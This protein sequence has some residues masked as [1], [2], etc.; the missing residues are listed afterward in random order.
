MPVDTR[1]DTHDDLLAPAGSGATAMTAPLVDRWGRI[2]R[3]LRISVTDACNIRCRYCM[4]AHPAPFLPVQRLLS[5]E[6]IE[7]LVRAVVPMGVTRLRLTGGEPLLRPH[8]ADLVARLCRVDGVEDIALTTNG[9]LL[10]DQLPALVEAGLRRVN[11]SLDTLEE[12]VFQRL[13]RRAGLDRVLRGI[14]AAVGYPGLEVKLNALVLRDVNLEGVVDLVEFALPRGIP[15]RFIEFMPLDGDG[16]W[17]RQQVVYGAELRRRIAEK[18]G[19][20]Q[21]VSR[22]DPARPA[23]EY[24]VAG[25]E[26]TLGFIDT[27]SQPFCDTCDRLRLTADGRL[28]NCL[29]GKEEWDV[30]TPLQRGAA[31]DEIRQRVRACIAAKHQAHGINQQNF[32]P[33]HRAMYQIGG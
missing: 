29:F 16:C 26:A 10:A 4:P 6:L 25:F 2:H 8:L 24:R 7:R 3:S 9:I 18:F 17:S 31:D 5:F 20:L 19:Q 14:D 21:A 15:L 28:R 11:I 23:V 22:P 1:T 30:A 12:S 33:P 13:S 27:V 32:T